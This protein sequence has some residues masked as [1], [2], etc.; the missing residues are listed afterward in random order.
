MLQTIADTIVAHHMLENCRN[1]IVGIS[2]G[3]DSVCLLSVLFAY[4]KENNLPIQLTAAHVN[5]GL[6]GEAADGDEAQVRALCHA[7]NIPLKIRHCQVV[8]LAKEQGI[9]VEMAGR[10]AR[11]AFFQ[12]LADG[13]PDCKIAVAHNRDDRAETILWNVIRG[14]GLDGLKGISYVRDNVIRP[15]LDVSKEEIR[16]YCKAQGLPVCEDA[17]NWETDYNRN[18]IR[19]ELLPYMEEKF[20]TDMTEKI[21]RLSNNILP[22]EDYLQEQTKIAYEACFRQGALERKAFLQLHPAMQIRVLKQFFP[23][24]PEQVHLYQLQQFM[25]EAATG[26]RLSLP[27][28]WCAVMQYDRLLLQKAQDTNTEASASF[29]YPAEGEVVLEDLGVKVICQVRPIVEGYLPIQTNKSRVQVFDYD[30]I[31]EACVDGN[32]TLCV[33]NRREGDWIRP[34]KGAGR[35]SLKKFFIDEKIP[36]ET[37]DAVPLLTLGQE[38]LWVMGYRRCDGYLPSEKTKQCFWISLENI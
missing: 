26:K 32:C 36:R 18:K 28:G 21:L 4:I 27:G 9:S 30:R 12:E 33:R 11:Y 13:L 22:E 31:L 29:G 2:G 10:N 7:W 5:H 24:S 23:H 3:A 19:L 6:R 1:L 37:R 15:L 14:T 16:N 17:T 38:V 20:Q 34:W 8:H 25:Q 35:K